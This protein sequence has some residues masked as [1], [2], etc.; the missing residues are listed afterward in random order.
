MTVGARVLGFADTIPNSSSRLDTISGGV[1]LLLVGI[2]VF[3][4]GNS[5]PSRWGALGLMLWGAILVIP[6]AAG[7]A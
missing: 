7:K 6:V 5:R 4:M 3:I 1:M 2:A